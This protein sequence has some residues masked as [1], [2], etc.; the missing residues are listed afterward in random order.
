MSVLLL[1]V[2]VLCIMPSVNNN[3]TAVRRLFKAKMPLKITVKRSSF[4]GR[5]DDVIGLS[6]ISPCI[7]ASSNALLANDKQSAVLCTSSLLTKGE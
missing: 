7:V 6:T 2:V 5:V 1:L 3:K 4:L